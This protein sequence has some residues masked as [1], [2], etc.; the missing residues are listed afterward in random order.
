MNIKSVRHIVLLLFI[1][2]SFLISGCGSGNDVL[3]PEPSRHIE[4]EGQKNFR[5]LGGYKNIDGRSIRWRMLFRSGDLFE[6]TD[7]DLLVVN[8]LGLR[9]IVDFRSEKEIE[10]RP[11]RSP[12]GAETLVDSIDIPGLSELLDHVLETG[13]TSQLTVGATADLYK[14]IYT[15]Y[16]EQFMIMFSEVINNEKRPVLIHCRGGKDRTGFGAALILSLLH[17]PDEVI[18]EDYLLSNEYLKEST[19]KDLQYMREAIEENTG[20][21]PTGEDIERIRNLLEVREEYLESA[22]QNVLDEYETFENYI[23]NGLGIPEVY[24]AEFRSRVLVPFS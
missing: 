6:L 12:A 10:E 23:V 24:I 8:D 21:T 20:H 14:N 13:D 5:D 16:K 4:L 7:A 11:D 2:A 3:Q 22:F 19:E 17:V 15:D 1:I 9:L 18:I